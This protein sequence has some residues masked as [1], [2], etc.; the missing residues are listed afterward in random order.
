MHSI[1]PRVGTFQVVIDYDL[2]IIYCLWQKIKLSFPF[3]IINH[4][5]KA[6]KPIKSTSSVPYGMLM[7]VIFKHFGVPLEGEPKDDNVLS[8]GEKNF[9]SLK[10]NPQPG[11]EKAFTYYEEKEQEIFTPSH[12]SH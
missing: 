7:T 5:I 3:L 4:M 1:L 10:L 8:S 11:I 2:M 12:W 6:T 9:V